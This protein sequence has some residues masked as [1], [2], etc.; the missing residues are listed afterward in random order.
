M[1]RL[2]GFLV[3]FLLGCGASA[4]ITGPEREDPPVAWR[5]AVVSGVQPAEAVPWIEQG[6]RRIPAEG[7]EPTGWRIVLH[8]GRVRATNPTCGGGPCPPACCAGTTDL[9]ARRIDVTWLEGPERLA[10]VACWE[11]SNA[12]FG[13]RDRDF[14]WCG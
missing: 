2:A 14:S 9:S 13:G 4:S 5:G 11:L 10:A 8:E 7:W 3:V 6:Y 1:N 12:R